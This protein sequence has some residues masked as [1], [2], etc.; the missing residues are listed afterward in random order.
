MHLATIWGLHEERILEWNG[1][2]EHPLDF[3][4][5]SGERRETD[6]TRFRKKGTVTVV[7]TRFYSEKRGILI[8]L[9][10]RS[11]SEKLEK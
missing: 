1:I 4:F 9:R 8:L 2:G 10:A 3:P 5:L 6:G 11:W 7:E